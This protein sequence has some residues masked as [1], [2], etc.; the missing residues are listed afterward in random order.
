MML[1]KSSF[2]VVF[3]LF[4]ICHLIIFLATITFSTI[5]S[6]DALRHRDL[7]KTYVCALFLSC[8]IYI[9]ITTISWL[10]AFR[11]SYIYLY[12]SSFILAIL[13]GIALYLF[14]P[15]RLS[16]ETFIFLGFL[17]LGV[18]YII[19][20]IVAMF[21]NPVKRWVNEE[22]YNR[23]KKSLNSVYVLL[24]CLLIPL[25]GVKIFSLT[26]RTEADIYL[27][28]IIAFESDNEFGVKGICDYNEETVFK[29]KFRK[30]SLANF[31]LNFNQESPVSSI[32]IAQSSS[33]YDPKI[34]SLIVKFS[35]GIE[36]I[37]QFKENEFRK[38]IEFPGIVSSKVSIYL[39]E[40]YAKEVFE[41]VLIT[42]VNPKFSTPY[43]EEFNKT[44]IS[45][46]SPK[47]YNTNPDS[48]KFYEADPNE[49]D[50]NIMQDDE[51]AD[52]FFH[53]LYPD[54]NFYKIIEGYWGRTLNPFKIIGFYQNSDNDDKKAIV[55]QL[56]S[57]NTYKRIEFDYTFGIGLFPQ[58][59][60][61]IKNIFF[62]DVNEDGIK[63][64]IVVESGEIRKEYTSEEFNEETQKM[65]TITLNPLG[66]YCEYSIF[67][68]DPN[69]EN[70]RLIDSKENKDGTCDDAT[71]K[72]NIS[73]K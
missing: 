20:L 58:T 32:Y 65:Q 17:L 60:S 41:D 51:S 30:D 21:Y 15:H 22:G 48:N 71:I 11:W 50:P 33:L 3:R 7:N 1:N 45:G 49:E 36:K 6:Y 25:A 9:F 62:Q 52:V 57:D 43:F 63:E 44:Y 69:N 14:P 10:F 39:K 37:V 23:K 40:I 38:N 55:L 29:W 42:E 70:I 2:P 59:H 64:M 35:N 61:E 18:F 4:A 26:K 47:I 28:S 66:D 54:T 19:F 73:A 67:E 5:A 53:R 13:I 56:S 24:A 27:K 72:K 34:K 68:Q 31:V 12:T 16:E 8:A 46:E